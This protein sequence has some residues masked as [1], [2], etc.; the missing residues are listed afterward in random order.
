M[1]P[2]KLDVSYFVFQ[3]GE[4]KMKCQPWLVQEQPISQCLPGCLSLWPF[5][6]RGYPTKTVRLRMD[7]F[8][9]CVRS[10]WDNRGVLFLSPLLPDVQL[11]LCAF[12]S[13]EFFHVIAGSRSG[14]DF[15]VERRRVDHFSTSPSPSSL[16]T[17]TV[18]TS[19][20]LCNACFKGGRSLM[21]L[22]LGHV[23]PF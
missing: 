4:P 23:A 17:F 21:L 1:V 14:R 18:F 11:W 3:T 15:K 9:L 12:G 13:C 5:S 22:R 2:R 16:E 8:Y 10:S 19:N 6:H 20:Y 7:G